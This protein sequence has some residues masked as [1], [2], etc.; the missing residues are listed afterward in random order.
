MFFATAIILHRVHT[1]EKT[2]AYS[3]N[4]AI[5][6]T[7]VLT[8]IAIYYCITIEVLA[9]QGSFAIMVIAAAVRTSRLINRRV[10]DEGLKARM[11][12]ISML[13]TGK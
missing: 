3:R 4:F 5:S 11:K 13:G 1:F 10:V 6:I 12:G 8:A 7:S 2:K 9:H